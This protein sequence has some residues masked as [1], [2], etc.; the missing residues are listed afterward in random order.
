VSRN[1]IISLNINAIPILMIPSLVLMLVIFCI[2][3]FYQLKKEIYVKIGFVLI[4]LFVISLIPVICI[5]NTVLWNFWSTSYHIETIVTLGTVVTI[6]CIPPVSDR[7]L[8]NGLLGLVGLL[9]IYLI[10][11]EPFNT[12]IL[13]FT[14]IAFSLF[15]FKRISASESKVFLTIQSV[16]ILLLGVTGFFGHWFAITGSRFLFTIILVLIVLV[17]SVRFFEQVVSM[18]RKIGLY[19]ITDPLT[20][21]FNKSF[22]K[23]K[24]QEHAAQHTIGI[25]FADI[26]NFKVLNDTKGHDFG[27]DVLRN[28]SRCLR[29]VLNDSGYACRFGGEELVGIVIKGNAEKFAETFR[30]KVESEIGVT[31]S[32]GV[33]IGQ[34]E[35]EHIIKLADTR[36]YKA[37]TNGKNKVV[38]S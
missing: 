2:Y 30:A 21:L 19:S 10:I 20:G 12:L 34:G 26:D 32:V 24:A 7:T 31:V 11:P 17:E 14:L 9:I 18:L 13:F 29:E 28:T 16:F 37:K 4:G 5:K 8:R 1:E 3:M 33:A 27:D 15:S 38:C 6:S 23:K 25:I 35:G 36:M 22:M